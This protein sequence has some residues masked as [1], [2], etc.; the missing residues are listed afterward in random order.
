VSRPVEPD[1]FTQ[2]AL[3]RLPI[4]AHSPTFWDE[5]ERALDDASEASTISVF[6]RPDRTD[7]VPIPAPGAPTTTVDDTL[8]LVPPALRRRSN[9]LLVAV[10]AAAVV[11]VVFA[12]TSLVSEQSDDDN[13]DLADAGDAAELDRLVEDAQPAAATPVTLSSTHADASSDAVSAW[14]DALHAGDADAAWAAMGPASQDHF[15][16]EAAFQAELTA[17]DEDL[18]AWSEVEPDDV[19]VTPVLATDGGTVAVVTLVGTTTVAGESEHRAEAFPVRI[20]DGEVVLEP[21]AV[22]GEL[23]LVVPAAVS[24][25]GEQPPV[26]AGE[27]LVVVVPQGVEAPVLRL[28]GTDPV[29]CGVADGTELRAMDDMPVQRCSYLPPAGMTPGEHTLT[30]AFTG[31]DGTSISA[32]ALL[33]QAA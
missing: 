12:G 27:E 23:E 9:A 25:S 33:F 19:L 8:A 18:G 30:V 21:F 15:G 14:V 32:D 26:E 28:D 10:A 13:A 16:T 6:E 1:Q 20:V 22:A 31:A 17:M 7:Q 4:P 2:T 24:A 11:M 5:L 29:V 3:R